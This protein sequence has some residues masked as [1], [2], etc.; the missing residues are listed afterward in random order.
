MGGYRVWE[1]VL[2]AMP[3]MGAAIDTSFCIA[4]HPEQWPLFAAIIRAAGV[5]RVF[6]GTDSPWEDQAASLAATRRF[7]AASGFRPEETAAILGGNA[8]RE[9]G[10]A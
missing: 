6:F 9:L 5:S 7:L 10:I 1:E 8:A 4:A 3:A 2:A